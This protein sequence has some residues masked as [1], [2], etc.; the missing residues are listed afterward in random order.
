M[1]SKLKTYLPLSLIIV[2]CLGWFSH[3]AYSHFFTQKREGYSFPVRENSPVY[4]FTNPLLFVDNSKIIFHEL[5]PLKDTL[6]EYINDA[7]SKNS[8]ENVS[9]YY[10]DLN[11]GKWTGVNENDPFLPSSMLKV[12]ILMVY[13]NLAESDPSILSSKLHFHAPDNYFGQNFPPENKLEEG[14]YSVETLLRQMIIESDNQA[15]DIL[16]TTKEKELLTFYKTLLLPMPPEKLHDYMSAVS[17]STLFR[18]LYGSTYLQPSLSEQVLKLLSDT[19]FHLG[20]VAGVPKETVVAHKFGEHTIF[21]TDLT[22]PTEYELHD[23]GIV[24]A[25]NSP[26]L[27]CI[28]TKGGNFTDL[29]K[30]LKDISSIIY[31]YHRNNR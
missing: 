13:L 24:Y 25:P 12:A 31:T 17:F 27:V 8:L 18:T 29:E 9:V 20:L 30:T 16:S 4:K 2:F 19:K 15:A 11:T 26:Y 7:K 5:D 6:N 21:H 28:M 3:T 22:K 10:R 23:C 14:D 1:V